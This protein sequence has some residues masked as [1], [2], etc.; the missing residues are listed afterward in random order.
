MRR[1]TVRVPASHYGLLR[2]HHMESH[3]SDRGALIFTGSQER[4]CFAL[5]PGRRNGAAI[6][7]EGSGDLIRFLCF[8]VRD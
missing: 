8:V 3:C 7:A 5:V 6:T 4:M 1:Q 2:L